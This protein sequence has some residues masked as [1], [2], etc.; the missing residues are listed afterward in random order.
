MSDSQQ[1]VQAQWEEK[2]KAMGRDTHSHPFTPSRSLPN[3]CL[4]CGNVRAARDH[5]QN[6]GS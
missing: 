2:Q 5:I 4:L 6:D 1:E 3:Y